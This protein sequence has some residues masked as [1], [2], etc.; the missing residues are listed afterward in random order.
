MSMHE[1]SKREIDIMHNGEVGQGESL[2][3]AKFKK[4]SLTKSNGIYR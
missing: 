3:S 1:M 2:V 4:E